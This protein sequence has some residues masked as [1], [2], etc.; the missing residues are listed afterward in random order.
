MSFALFAAIV[1]P[2]M[3]YAGP[4]VDASGPCP[5][6]AEIGF[7]GFSPGGN[8][9]VIT[10][11]SEGSFMV[12]VG[13]C[14]GTE[15]GLDAPSYRGSWGADGLGRVMLTPTLSAGACGLLVQGLDLDTCQLS[16]IGEVGASPAAVDVHDVRGGAVPE[17]TLVRLEGLVV[18][19]V[20]WHGLY[21]Q[22]PADPSFGGI[23]VFLAAGYEDAFGAFAPGDVITVVG[24]YTSYFDLDEINV[25]GSTAPA[26]EVTGSG[27][28]PAPVVVSAGM[29]ETDGDRYEST[30]VVVEDVQVDSLAGAYGEFVVSDDTGSVVVD[31][32]FYAPEPIAIGTPLAFVQGPLTYSFGTFKIEPRDAADV[33]L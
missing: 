29:L 19:A 31:D 4:I 33:G 30:L 2:T 25:I 10:A 17:G 27:P 12:P 9:A 23:W 28:V 20:A 24:D 8:V 15:V 26:V 14:A 1:L 16:N 3:A 21:A 5:G 7:A 32:L 11:A 6:P 22:D 18:T 13:P